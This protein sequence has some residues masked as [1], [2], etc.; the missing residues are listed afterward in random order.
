M[1]I[2]GIGVLG[3]LEPMDD[4]VGQRRGDHLVADLEG[5]AG[6]H[7]V[8]ES[9]D[10]VDAAEGERD[11]ENR[12]HGL[13]DDSGANR[14]RPEHAA[15]GDQLHARHCVGVGEFAGPE[16]D[17]A[18]CKDA[19]DETEDSG[20]GLLVLPA[21]GGRQLDDDRSHKVQQRRTE[22]AQPDGAARGS[23]AVD[24]GEDVSE[25]VG[26][27]KQQHG[28]AHCEGANG[29][30]AHRERSKE[31][32]LLRDQIRHE[33]DDDERSGE[34]VEIFIPADS[35]SDSVVLD[36]LALHRLLYQYAVCAPRLQIFDTEELYC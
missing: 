33:Q 35:R 7:D 18:G 14:A 20:E 12:V 21:G 8:Q 22:E 1:T 27:G 36:G 30:T 2:E 15:I 17:E 16:G 11:D 25:D 13:A 9:A 24:L 4:Q 28:A 29:P 32:H 26:D 6:G 10:W 19:R 31:A 34:S 23:V 3:P 5:I